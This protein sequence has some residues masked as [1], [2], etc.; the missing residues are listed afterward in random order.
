M[1]GASGSAFTNRRG[2]G[3]GSVWDRAP[4]VRQTVKAQIS[5]NGEKT[6]ESVSKKVHE[7][8]QRSRFEAACITKFDVRGAGTGSGQGTLATNLSP[9]GAIKGAYIDKGNVIHGFL[10]PAMPWRFF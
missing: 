5:S 2:P 10:R 3:E 9:A 1:H 7:R 8:V 6:Y 4:K